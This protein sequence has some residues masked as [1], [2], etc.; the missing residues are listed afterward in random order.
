MRY[1]SSDECV[2]ARKRIDPEALLS[3]KRSKQLAK[4]RGRNE[5]HAIRRRGR[6]P[7]YIVMG[8]TALASLAMVVAGFLSYT[9]PH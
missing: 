5:R 4:T 8:L 7:M 9:P 1:D 6:L 3:K 2:I